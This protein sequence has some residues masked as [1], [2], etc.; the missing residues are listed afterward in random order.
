MSSRQCGIAATAKHEENPSEGQRMSKITQCPYC[1]KSVEAIEGEYLCSRCSGTYHID[2]SGNTNKVRRSKGWLIATNCA[3]VSLL[4]IAAVGFLSGS[5]SY[6]GGSLQTS[7]TG[8]RVL[9]PLLI[10]IFS[11]TFFFGIIHAL[12]TG[13][14]PLGKRSTY[15][16]DGVDGFYFCLVVAAIAAILSLLVAVKMGLVWD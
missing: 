2:S 3:S 13:E 7:A 5:F 1:S 12:R 6:S 10:G 9:F 4:L 8:W 16:E 15:R 11:L 14:L